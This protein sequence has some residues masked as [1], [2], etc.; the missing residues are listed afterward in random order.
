MEQVPTSVTVVSSK[1]QDTGHIM[2]PN[3]T[4][5]ADDGELQAVVATLCLQG[6]IRMEGYEVQNNMQ[7][8]R[9]PLRWP[10]SQFP[11]EVCSLGLFSLLNSRGS[12]NQPCVLQ[13]ISN[14]IF[15]RIKFKSIDR[16]IDIYKGIS[17]KKKKGDVRKQKKKMHTNTSYSFSPNSNSRPILWLRNGYVAL[18]ILALPWGS[19][20]HP[21]L[22][23]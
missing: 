8:V 23:P 20:V 19:R 22:H 5:N 16:Y 9:V 21:I 1:S 7:L 6:L 17:A 14:L 3:S 18:Q 2:L 4:V 10:L 13:G 15:L 12:K 11:S